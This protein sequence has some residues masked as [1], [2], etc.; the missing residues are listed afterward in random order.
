MMVLADHGLRASTIGTGLRRVMAEMQQPGK[1][2]AEILENNGIA[3]ENLRPNVVGFEAAMKL[4]TRVLWDN[5]K[6]TVDIAKAYKIFELR[7]AQAAAILVKAFNS[8]QFKEAQAT[9]YDVGSAARMAATQQEGLGVKFSKL[10]NQAKLAALAIGDAGVTGVLHGLVDALRTVAS[11]IEGFLSTTAGEFIVKFTMM[12]GAIGVVGLGLQALGVFHAVRVAVEFGRVVAATNLMT[13]AFWL[14][15]KPLAGLLGPI[16]L[17]A[18]AVGGLVA[19]LSTMENQQRKSA[20]AAAKA[21]VE[22]GR[23]AKGLELYAG[24]L[25]KLK[26]SQD[27]NAADQYRAAVRRVAEEYKHLGS[28]TDLLAM[29]HEDLMRV[30]RENA[31][32]SYTQ[33]LVNAISALR[34]YTSQP[35]LSFFERVSRAISTMHAESASTAQAEEQNIEKQRAIADTQKTII[36]ILRE[37][38]ETKKITIEQ[39]EEYTRKLVAENLISQQYAEQ[40]LAAIVKALENIE[41]A[42]GQVVD[43]LKMIREMPPGLKRIY[44]ALSIKDKIEFFEKYKQLL[45]KIESDK[46]AAAKLGLDAGKLEQERI[47]E[48]EATFRV[49]QQVKALKGE[50]KA[51]YDSLGAKDKLDFIE[52]WKAF[53]SEIENIRKSLKEVGES[54]AAINEIIRE[55]TEDF[56]KSLKGRLRHQGADR[57]SA[58][59]VRNPWRAGIGSIFWK[60]WFRT[61]AKSSGLRS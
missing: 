23:T 57:G 37:G 32:E 21:S 25:E 39:A 54:E 27:T 13:A 51:L 50:F 48:F 60:S 2:L 1:D 36:N 11:G 44:D 12:A 26:E 41:G 4:L 15:N 56:K 10:A 18:I 34:Q 33:S 59:A 31:F 46:K 45:N 38:V 9:L 14:L 30:L 28:E 24:H 22:Y 20:E 7:G 53:D 42:G 17:I 55:K 49:T 40:G 61:P 16:G 29:K 52:K 43:V 19:L 5:E 6:K 58:Q 3:L 47:R 35:D 8:G